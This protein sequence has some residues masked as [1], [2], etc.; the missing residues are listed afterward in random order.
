MQG[1]KIEGIEV[2][3]TSVVGAKEWKNGKIDTGCES[4][5]CYNLRF[6]KR[7]NSVA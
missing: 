1:K 5:E 4:V 3:W 7:Q 2:Q 6:K